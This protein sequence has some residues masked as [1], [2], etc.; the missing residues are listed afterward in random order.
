MS[1]AP[2]APFDL[3][4]IGAGPGGFAGAMR[5]VD[6][7]R[8][9]CLIEADEIGGTGVKWG[10]LA[11]KTMWELAK[12]YAVAAKRDRGYRCRDLQVSYSAVRATVMTAIEEKQQQMRRQLAVFAEGRRTAPGSIAY[13]QGRGRLAGD[14]RVAIALNDGT[15]REIRADNILIV[16][17]SKPRRFA[18]IPVDQQRIFDSDGILD[19]QRFP[20]RL[21]IIG[22]GVTGCE[23]A[24]I[25]SNF[26]QTKVF[27]VDHQEMILPYE[28][29]DV[30][31]F[32][33]RNLEH[34]GVTILHSARLRD[35]D[36]NS[37]HLE[38]ALDFADGNETVVAVDAVLISIGRDP[39]TRGLGLASAGIVPDAAGFL[40]CD[41]DCRVRGRIYAAGD[42]THRPALVNMAVMESRHAV[43]HMFRLPTRPLSFPNMSTVMFF[44]PAVAAVGLNEKGCRQRG[45][46]YRVATYTNALLP[47]AIA[48]RATRGFVKIIVSDDD[49]QKIL[50]MRAAGPQVSSTIM[51]IALLIDQDMDVREVVGSM[52]P[53]PTMS[54]VIQECLR[55]LMGKS[56]YKPEAF[57]DHLTIRR[58]HPTP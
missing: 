4:I 12:D 31:A 3:C 51:T 16:T 7:G 11:S 46:T 57:P 2:F 8:R 27:L 30:S 45:L 48:M 10:A 37:D 13:L 49:Q 1:T 22:A 23:Y 32:V 9:V 5:A 36:Q 15:E 40:D 17:G 6:A 25:F 24:T 14:D 38:V 55:L 53:H 56:I 28:D 50:G 20:P 33:S 43:K 34:S 58:W 18:H 44:N 52:F 42:V 47:R 21:M 29:T 41:A 19:L 26:G 54:E 35:I 39:N